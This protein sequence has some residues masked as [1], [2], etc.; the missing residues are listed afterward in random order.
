MPRDPAAGAPHMSCVLQARGLTGTGV[1]A[2]GRGSLRLTPG[3]P[4]LQA[5]EAQVKA[6]E[7]E[8]EQVDNKA[9]L[10]ATLQ[11][12]AAIRQEHR[13]ERQRR[14]EAAVSAG[15]WVPHGP[16]STSAGPA[17]GAG[18][19]RAP[20]SSWVVGMVR[21]VCSG[22]P[23]ASLACPGCAQDPGP[24]RASAPTRVPAQFHAGVRKGPEG[25][26]GWAVHAPGHQVACTETDGGR[27]RCWAPGVH[28]HVAGC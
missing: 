27:S 22:S 9:K 6:A 26:R 11:E 18:L 28:R 4:S 25:G 8:G 12:E 24:G 10:E 3:A 2:S 5:K 17:V 13:E 19:C 15:R 16:C 23:R 7:V 20:L 1:W 21:Q 14:S